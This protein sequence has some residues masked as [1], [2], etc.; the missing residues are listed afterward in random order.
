MFF[1]KKERE[2]AKLLSI[3]ILNQ[4]ITLGTYAYNF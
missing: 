1:K 4:V 2:R 3:L